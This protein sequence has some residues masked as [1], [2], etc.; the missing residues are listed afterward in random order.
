[1]TGTAYMNP[2]AILKSSRTGGFHV[3]GDSMVTSSNFITVQTMNCG[4][5]GTE[6]GEVQLNNIFV[7]NMN[8]ALENSDMNPRIRFP[9][10]FQMGVKLAWLDESAYE[11]NAQE[12]YR[13]HPST[14]FNDGGDSVFFK[15][16]I[17]A[18]GNIRSSIITR[19]PHQF[20]YASL[21]AYGAGA[22]LASYAS[23]SPSEIAE[24]ALIN[25]DGLFTK[26]PFGSASQFPAEGRVVMFDLPDPDYGMLSLG[27]LR[28]A[29]I[30]PFSWHPSYIVGNSLLPLSAPSSYSAHPMLEE[31]Y[32]SSPYVENT[33]S[34]SF[35]YW[36]GGVRRPNASVSANDRYWRSYLGYS[37]SAV[38]W[39]A[40][41]GTNPQF[42]GMTNNES[43]LSNG[44][45]AVTKTIGGTLIDSEDEILDY[46]ICY[47]VNHNL[48]D[49]YFLS[50]MK[51]EASSLAMDWEAG[52]A[53]HQSGYRYNSYASYPMD[54][55]SSK[56]KSPSEG[57]AF[58]FWNNGYLIASEA[59]FNVNS[60]SVDA[61]TALL[62]GTRN[63]QR[64]TQEE[65][66][67]GASSS[68]ILTADV[69]E[70]SSDDDFHIVS[71]VKKPI[72]G[73]RSEDQSP[74]AQQAYDG[75]RVLTCLLYTSPSP[76]DRG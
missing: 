2:H 8:T 6:G 9:R 50:G 54:K 55:A 72:R 31:L 7:E 4:Q 32:R 16:A 34:N 13:H 25:L 60:V 3:S 76:R 17:V 43:L 70:N 66:V 74:Y 71:R 10:R 45:E 23:P 65:N 27:A 20:T 12:S 18:Y 30:S 14:G 40:A 42:F 24:Q 37:S 5:G 26:T 47:E 41:T 44:S 57:L 49:R 68:P 51:L 21:Y 53:L 73:D 62:S 67:T 11:G 58:G 64:V 39:G 52:K 48:F 56:L 15:P 59:Q 19:A 1:M 38:T 63:R 33:V 29:E 61:W 69:L 28:H 36:L 35:D 46:D 22:W 75:A